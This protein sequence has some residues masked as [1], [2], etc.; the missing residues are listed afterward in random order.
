MGK[1]QHNMLNPAPAAIIWNF[2][3][4]DTPVD[5]VPID[6]PPCLERHAANYRAN[7]V[8]L[9]TR[10]RGMYPNAKQMFVTSTPIP[11]NKS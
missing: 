1:N 4:H 5:C 6:D 11:Y 10:I 7:L 8:S 9:H 2:G 3:I